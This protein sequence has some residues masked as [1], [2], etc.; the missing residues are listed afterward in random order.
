ML[1]YFGDALCHYVICRHI[2]YH[3]ISLMNDRYVSILCSMLPSFALKLHVLEMVS[4]RSL[5]VQD[6]SWPRSEVCGK[7]CQGE[8]QC[9]IACYGQLS[10]RADLQSNEEQFQET[11]NLKISGELLHQCQG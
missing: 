9:I 6:L 5:Q 1:G 10:Y 8:A 3:V 11:M 4:E 2:I 7:G